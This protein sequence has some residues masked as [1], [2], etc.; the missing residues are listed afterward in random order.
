[1]G[2]PSLLFSCNSFSSRQW[3]T[4][5]PLTLLEAMKNFRHRQMDRSR[6]VRG[7]DKFIPSKKALVPS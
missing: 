2:I 5:L 4:S 7:R 6:H 1:M 3:K